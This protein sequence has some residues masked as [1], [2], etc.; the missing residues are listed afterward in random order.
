MRRV[1][2]TYAET[3]VFFLFAAARPPCITVNFGLFKSNYL[4]I[5][6]QV[7]S[8]P[9]LKKIT[10][11]IKIIISTIDSGQNWDIIEDV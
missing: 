8:I 4:S 10:S 1:S 5:P 11:Q 9:D 2:V 3:N 7:K 6:F